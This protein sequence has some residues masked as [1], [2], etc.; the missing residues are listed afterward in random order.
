MLDTIKHITDEIFFFQEDSTLVHMHAL[1]CQLLQH[2]GL[3]F[4]W[5]MPPTAR[6]ERIDYKIYLVGVV[7]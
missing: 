7:S 3:T 2:S 6:A 5:T 4:S 1:C